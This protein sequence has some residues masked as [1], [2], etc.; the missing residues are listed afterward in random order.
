MSMGRH[1]LVLPLLSWLF[2]SHWS[3]LRHPSVCAHLSM[4]FCA[5]NGEWWA[6]W[7]FAKHMCEWGA[8][9]CLHHQRDLCTQQHHTH[10]KTHYFLKM[11]LSC[12]VRLCVVYVYVHSI[13]VVRSSTELR[14]AAGRASLAALE[15]SVHLKLHLWWLK[16]PLRKSYQILPLT[17][18][19]TRMHACPLYIKASRVL[20]TSNS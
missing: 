5:S 11:H 18:P 2:I 14:E 6:G 4:C 13:D 17:L 1:L 15:F 3:R 19:N 20:K 10:Q 7:V 16:T 12:I 8:A 9:A